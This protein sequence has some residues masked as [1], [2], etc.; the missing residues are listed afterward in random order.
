MVHP[1]WSCREE[2]TS[3]CKFV[4]SRDDCKAAQKRFPKKTDLNQ[5]E[6]KEG[7]VHVEYL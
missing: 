6:I 3:R 7:L 1:R 4:F 2:V 5:A